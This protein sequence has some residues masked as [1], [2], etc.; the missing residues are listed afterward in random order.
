MRKKSV[1]IRKVDMQEV[2]MYEVEKVD[3]NMDEK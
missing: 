3:S 1:R 2:M